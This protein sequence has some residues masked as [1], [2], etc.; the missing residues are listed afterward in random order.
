LSVASLQ[1]SS[2]DARA[3]SNSTVT[4]RRWLR[5][6]TFREVVTERAS[7]V[8]VSSALKRF[9]MV[10]PRQLDLFVI[11]GQAQRVQLNVGFCQVIAGGRVPAMIRERLVVRLDGAIEQFLGPVFLQTG[12][13]SAD[14][15]T[16]VVRNVKR[17]VALD[18]I[19]AVLGRFVQQMV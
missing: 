17:T 6:G 10:M 4:G 16:I 5:A 12:S 3:E 9:P 2:I 7:A 14:V 11:V 18:R 15:A 1:N 19:H 13:L 8:F